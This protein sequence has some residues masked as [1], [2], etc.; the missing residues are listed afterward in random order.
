MRIPLRAHKVLTLPPQCEPNAL[1]FVRLVDS[2]DLYVTATDGTPSLVWSGP[3]IQTAIDD[4]LA[5]LNLSFEWASIAGKPTSSPTA[6]DAAVQLSH[7]HINSAILDALG[8]TSGQLTYNGQPVDTE[9]NGIAL[10]GGH[11]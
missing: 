8:S 6:I 11:F 3:R 5:Q 9:I 10:D 4:A 7:T 1:Y 2:L